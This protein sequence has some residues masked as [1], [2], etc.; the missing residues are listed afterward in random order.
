LACNFVHS[1]ED[2]ID[3]LNLR[4]GLGFLGYLSRNAAIKEENS[5]LELL[6]P[7]DR[8]KISNLRAL[9]SQLKP[10]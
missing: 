3:A 10:D 1:L 6:V 7:F 8:K 9:K 4:E 2:K 5:S